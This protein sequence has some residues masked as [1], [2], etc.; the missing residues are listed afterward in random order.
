MKPGFNDLIRNINQRLEG[1]WWENEDTLQENMAVVRELLEEWRRTLTGGGDSLP[2]EGDSLPGGT[3]EE[4][5]VVGG[6]PNLNP[7]L[8]PFV[9]DFIISVIKDN[10]F[11]P[12]LTNIFNDVL[13][14][15]TLVGGQVLKRISSHPVKMRLLLCP[16]VNPS[17]R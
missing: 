16:N 15:T 4:E 8:F 2:G 1:R 12:K 10:N 5:P 14:V 3:V 7:E 11:T 9:N 17:F 13:P 6:D